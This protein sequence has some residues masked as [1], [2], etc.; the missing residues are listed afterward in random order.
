MSLTPHGA[1]SALVA[2]YMTLYSSKS[3]PAEQRAAVKREVR[4]VLLLR[5]IRLPLE[6]VSPLL[7]METLQRMHKS[8]ELHEAS[9]LEASRTNISIV[10]M[11][12]RR[13]HAKYGI[14]LT[15]LLARGK[16]PFAIHQV[17]AFLL[18]V[19]TKYWEM[20]PEAEKMAG[21]RLSNIGQ[22]LLKE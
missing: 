9:L 14:G 7:F 2:Y 17:L 13:A 10:E 5:A 19:T 8:Q 11:A 22:R 4:N 6:V 12:L 20:L 3:S 16:A 15:Q 1:S 18:D 21:F